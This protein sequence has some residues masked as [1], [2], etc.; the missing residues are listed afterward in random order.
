MVSRTFD[1][2][3]FRRED[4]HRV[5]CTE[6]SEDRANGWVTESLPLITSSAG[7]RSF[8]RKSLSYTSSAYED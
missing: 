2:V 8:S 1:S 7:S 5:G 3:P 6:L 4:H